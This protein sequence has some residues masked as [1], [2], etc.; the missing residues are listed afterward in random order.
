M[1]HKALNRS[2]SYFEMRRNVLNLKA[3][4]VKIEVTSTFKKVFVWSF[5]SFRNVCFP[6]HY[7]VTVILKFKRHHRSLVVLTRL[8]IIRKLCLLQEVLQHHTTKFRKMLC[9]LI[10]VG[11]DWFI[12]L[13]AQPRDV[14]RTLP[15]I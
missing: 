8:G 6:S 1:F 11:M 10:F 3:K 14:F 12:D 7:L 13:L 4:F 15:N 5:V 2:L 9:L